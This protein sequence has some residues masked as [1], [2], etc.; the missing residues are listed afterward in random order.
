[1]IREIRRRNSRRK[2]R[3]LTIV[4]RPDFSTRLRLDA[5]ER[6]E[7][8]QSTEANVGQVTPQGAVD[9]VFRR[10]GK[11]RRPSRY[12]DGSFPV[13]YSSLEW[14]TAE[15]E[16]QY[17]APSYSGS[18][19]GRRTFH[20]QRLVCTFL[21]QEKDLRSKVAEWPDLVHPSGYTFC[22]RLGAEARQSGIDGLVVPSARHDGA[23][24]PVFRREA[25]RDPELGHL[26]SVTYDPDSGEVTLQ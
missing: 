25:I 16:I 21:G 3:R 12:S 13:F 11:G 23:N 19:D 2:V 17:W 4:P 10:R 9:S 5:R 22:N 18:P 24:V 14:K 1:M 20:Y 6:A 15:A 7:V 26:V 8:L